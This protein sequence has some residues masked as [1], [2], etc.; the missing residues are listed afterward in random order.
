MLERFLH[1]K[2]KIIEFDY[3]IQ[4]RIIFK[5]PVNINVQIYIIFL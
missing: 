3:I 2:M 4:L 1:K 5:D